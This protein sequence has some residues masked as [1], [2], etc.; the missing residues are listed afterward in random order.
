MRID[1]R[2]A[3]TLVEIANGGEIGNVCQPT[4]TLRKKIHLVENSR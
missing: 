1:K 3:S 4:S 2:T